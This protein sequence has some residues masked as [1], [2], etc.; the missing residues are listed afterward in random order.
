[1]DDCIFCKIVKG[2]IP[3]YKIYEDKKV[4]AFLDIKPL[5][6]GHTLLLPKQHFEN[7]LD[8]PE[9]LY[10]YMSKI[11]KKVSQVIQDKY[12]PEG[13]LINQNNGKRAGQEVP[14]IH[15]HIKPIYVDT[16]VFDEADHRKEFSQEQMNKVQEELSFS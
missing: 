4:I 14:H 8:I 13:I 10:Q 5:S 1:M 15:V 7:I 11:V 6:K 16:T 3:C 2:D 9:D 12:S